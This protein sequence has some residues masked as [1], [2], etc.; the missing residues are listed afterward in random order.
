MRVR[1]AEECVV[2]GRWRV[3]AVRKLEE[4]MQVVVRAV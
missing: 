4:G 1:V 3:Y 2:G